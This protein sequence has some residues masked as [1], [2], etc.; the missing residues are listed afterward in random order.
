M[1][2]VTMM[3]HPASSH[4]LRLFLLRHALAHALSGP[5]RIVSSGAGAEVLATVLSRTVLSSSSSSSLQHCG[6]PFRTCKHTDRT[7]HAIYRNIHC[8]RYAIQLANAALWNMANNGYYTAV[9]HR[10]PCCPT[11]LSTVHAAVS[12]CVMIRAVVGADNS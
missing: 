9:T 8:T 10:L 5:T 6:L 2:K 12:K 11:R 3:H 1:G 4:P 7:A